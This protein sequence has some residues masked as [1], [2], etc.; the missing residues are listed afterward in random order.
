MAVM[1]KFLITIIQVNL[2]SNPSGT[3]R[4]QHKFTAIK[5]FAISLPPQ[6]FF[7]R[8]L[9]FHIFFR[10]GLLGIAHFFFL[11][12]GCFGL[13]VTVRCEKQFFY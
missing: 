7:G 3:W 1:A 5:N 6:P 12:L 13:D 8:H 9:G 2:V 11:Q 10:N 4:R